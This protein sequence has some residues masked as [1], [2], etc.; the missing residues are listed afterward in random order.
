L[1]GDIEQFGADAAA[2]H[3]RKHVKL[4]DPAVTESDDPA[5]YIGI[6]AS[7]HAAR[8]E[9]TLAVEPAVIVPR[10]QPSEPGHRM[11]ECSPVNLRRRV[12]IGEREL[13]EH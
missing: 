3:S 6:E 5:Q 7:P 11:V 1:L 2:L 13:P 10:M 9:D 12:H 4:L 8:R